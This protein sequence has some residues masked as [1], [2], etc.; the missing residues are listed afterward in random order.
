[1]DERNGSITTKIK[2]QEAQCQLVEVS[3]E[4]N[5]MPQRNGRPALVCN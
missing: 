2:L 5:I 4:W 3:T 1:M